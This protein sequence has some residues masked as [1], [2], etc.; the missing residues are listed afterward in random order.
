MG[1]S[2]RSVGAD[3]AAEG[4]VPDVLTAGVGSVA[5]VAAAGAP[6]AAAP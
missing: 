6:T 3:L 2:D 4:T 5:A 1:E